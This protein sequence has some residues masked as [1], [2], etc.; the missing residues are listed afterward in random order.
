MVMKEDEFLNELEQIAPELSKL[1]KQQ[2]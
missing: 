1:Q 2:L